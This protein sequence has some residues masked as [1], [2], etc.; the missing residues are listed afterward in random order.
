[1]P[2]RQIHVTDADGTPLRVALRESR[3]RS[4][5]PTA[6]PA[7]V[8]Q[9]AAAVARRP[10]LPTRDATDLP[11]FTIDPPAS[12]DLDQ[13]VFLARR[14]AG[15]FRVH[16]A[17]ADVTA[18]VLPGS[19]L[20]AEAHRRVMTYYYPDV[21]VPLHPDV[22][23]EGAASLLPD[24]TRPAL[25]W[26]LDLD[27]DGRVVRTDVRRALVRSR[28]KL[29]YASVQ[30]ALDSG[31][32]EEPLSLLREVG[33]RREELEHT[34]G[35]IS[36]SLPEQRIVRR[37]N[38]YALVYRSPLPADRWNAQISLMTGM[39]A[40]EL[41]LGSGTGVLRTLPPA[42]GTAVTRLRRVARALGVTWPESM[43]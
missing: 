20:D 7:D 9:E 23:G 35:G 3:A 16:Y 4:G 18:F 39:A 2:R 30:R 28:A 25:L 17:I 38:H 6:F 22:L 12:K 40:A 14:A 13:A 10:R 34:R 15:G 19:A 42:P 24:H 32:A 21:R 29:S 27:T 8:L 33:L 37:G 43:A 36:L 31:A 41:M 1:M 5:M 26:E 11:L